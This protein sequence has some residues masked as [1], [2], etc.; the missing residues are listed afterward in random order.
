V[1]LTSTFYLTVLP[2]P[3]SVCVF[4]C[5]SM[6]VH[7]CVWGCMCIGEF[8]CIVGIQRTP[9]EVSV[10]RRILETVPVPCG[11]YLGCTWGWPVLG[12]AETASGSQA[13]DKT[14]G[15]KEDRAP[16]GCD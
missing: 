10:Q 2:L 5:V 15:A 13:L 16:E 11:G 1:W 14:Q 4:V 8:V 12:T 9:P 7:V 3:K 6:C